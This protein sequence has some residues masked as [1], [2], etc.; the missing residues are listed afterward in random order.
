MKKLR[1]TRIG[2][3]LGGGSARG[4]AHIGVIRALNQTGV[5]PDVV[6]GTSIGAFVGAAYVDGDLDRLEAWVRSLSLQTVVSFLDFS[7]IG[8][9]IKGEKLIDFSAATS[10]TGRSPSCRC[11]S[12]R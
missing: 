5:Y 12:L 6:C 8:G 11:R 9:L 7:L 1:N 4:W 3:A 2:L 10:S